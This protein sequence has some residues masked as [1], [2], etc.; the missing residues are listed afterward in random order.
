MSG[1]ASGHAQGPG[2]YYPYSRLEGVGK[3]EEKRPWVH[4]DH[5]FK[6]IPVEI[7]QDTLTYIPLA[8]TR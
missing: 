2:W 8:R 5:L 7:L 3:G 1:E 6:K 4:I